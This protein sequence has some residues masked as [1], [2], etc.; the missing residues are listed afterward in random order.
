MKRQPTNK[1]E[2]SFFQVKKKYNNVFLIYRKSLK[3][4]RVESCSRK[5]REREK[6]KQGAIYGILNVGAGKKTS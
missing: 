3:I 5:G 2:I 4:K 6:K 1:E